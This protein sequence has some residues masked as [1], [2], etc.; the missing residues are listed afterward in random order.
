MRRCSELDE[1][2]YAKPRIVM[3]LM[4]GENSREIT[5]DDYVETFP[6]SL[7]QEWHCVYITSYRIQKSW[8][9]VLR[10]NMKLSII[11]SMRNESLD[12]HRGSK[13]NIIPKEVQIADS[14][15]AAPDNRDTR[16]PQSLG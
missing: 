1:A 3:S 7:S 15:H 14:S 13:Y 8:Y 12:N 10:S 6:T 5:E 11:S 9:S 4:T 16:T 2:A